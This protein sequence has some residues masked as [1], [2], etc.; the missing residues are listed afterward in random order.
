MSAKLPHHWNW[1][2]GKFRW[3]RHVC[4]LGAVFNLLMMAIANLVGFVV[5]TDGVKFLFARLIGT[6]E[7]VRFT[8]LCCCCIF[9]AVHLMFEY[10]QDIYFLSFTNYWRTTIFLRAE[11]LRQGIVRRCWTGRYIWIDG[12]CSVIDTVLQYYET[13]SIQ[14]VLT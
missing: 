1:Q 14:Q 12:E 11:E 9:V 7:G 8:V 2:Y 4:A 10:R 5:G 6:W 3:Y 13:E